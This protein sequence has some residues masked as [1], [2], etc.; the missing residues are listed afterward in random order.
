MPFSGIHLT[1]HRSTHGQETILV[2]KVEFNANTKHVKTSQ[3]ILNVLIPIWT[4]SLLRLLVVT[5]TMSQLLF[6]LLFKFIRVSF[7]TF[8]LI[9]IGVLGP[10][11]A[12]QE[13]GI[14]SRCWSSKVALIAQTNLR[15][16]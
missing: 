9:F 2:N 1:M 15:F 10:C 11:G 6:L 16:I 5:I 8:I 14:A 13:G 7:I 12:K 4:V 3:E